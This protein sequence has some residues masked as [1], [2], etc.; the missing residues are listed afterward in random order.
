MAIARSDESADLHAARCT[1]LLAGLRDSPRCI[2]PKFFYDEQGS[3]LFS[4]ICEQPEY[5]PTRTE[6]GIF[7]EQ[8]AAIARA[9]G[10]GCR[11]IEPGAGGCEKVRYLLPALQPALYQPLDI[12]AEYMLA[13]TAALRREFPD[14]QVM[15]QVA[16]FSDHFE[17]TAVPCDGRAVLFYPGSTIG[18]FT[19]DEAEA[20]LRRATALLGTDGVLLIGVDLH[21]QK[22]VLEAAYNDAQGVT[23][24]FNRNI[25]RHA[26]RLLSADFNPDAFAH[27]AF[28]TRRCGA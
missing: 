2:N 24:A 25:L 11:L 16:D 15:P 21:K 1:E 19:P 9:V 8:A 22:S 6:I 5:Y 4:Q 17:L 12:S 14:L 10:P 3:A 27:L 13:G 28:T 20:F 18:N 26:N 23:A 7:T